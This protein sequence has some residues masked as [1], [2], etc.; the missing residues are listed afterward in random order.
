MPTHQHFN[1]CPNCGASHSRPVGNPFQCG[2]CGFH[3]YFNPTCAAAALIVDGQGRVLFIRRAKEPAL[4][5]LALPGGFIDFD[6]SAEEAV[7]REIS[8]EVGLRAGSLR[9]LCS[10]PNEYP[11]KGVT[12]RVL[13]FF[14]VA[15]APTDAEAGISEEVQ[16]VLWLDPAKVRMEDLAFPSLRFAVQ[17]FLQESA[18]G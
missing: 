1:F 8:E 16:S 11:Y 9:F 14:F 3:F 17:R 4:G 5:K 2:N 6:E 15:Q 7:R 12:Y 13:D 10:H 18:L